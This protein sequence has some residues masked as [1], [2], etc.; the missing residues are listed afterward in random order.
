MIDN[1][2]GFTE[3]TARVITYMFEYS[4]RTEQNS[5]LPEDVEDC[6]AEAY[7]YLDC[8]YPED[9]SEFLN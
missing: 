3:A 8:C 2:W 4:E 7:K 1:P 6:I 5:G 9:Y